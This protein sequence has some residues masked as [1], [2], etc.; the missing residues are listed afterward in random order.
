MATAKYCRCKNTYCIS[1][2]DVIDC[3]YPDYWRFGKGRDNT[4]Q[5]TEIALFQNGNNIIFQNDNK[6]EFN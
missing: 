2:C 3:K 5:A 4:P 1:C 6:L